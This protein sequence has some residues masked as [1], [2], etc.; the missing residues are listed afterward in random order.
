[1]I[2]PNTYMRFSPYPP[3][4]YHLIFNLIDILHCPR[5]STSTVTPPV[6]H[7]YGTYP[8]TDTCILIIIYWYQFENKMSSSVPGGD[9]LHN[10]DP[11]GLEPSTCDLILLITWQLCRHNI[12]IVNIIHT[13]DLTIKP[14]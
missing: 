12:D 11:F 3:T 14:A 6:T 8:L 9:I 2:A 10:R 13:R 5:K 4:P 1:M 7:T